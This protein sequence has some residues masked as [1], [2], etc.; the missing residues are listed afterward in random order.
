MVTEVGERPRSISDVKAHVVR[1]GDCSLLIWVDPLRGQM[2]GI[3]LSKDAV[4]DTAQALARWSKYTEP[5]WRA[6]AD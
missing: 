1:Y 3:L 5:S 4:D 2:Q 6:Q